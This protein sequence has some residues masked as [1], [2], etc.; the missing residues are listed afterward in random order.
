MNPNKETEWT[1]D[2]QEK[3]KR[4]AFQLNGLTVTEIAELMFCEERQVYKYL[5]G[6]SNIP[7]EKILRWCEITGE[8]PEDVNPRVYPSCCNNVINGYLGRY[9]EDA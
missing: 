8:K 6:T 7:P 9:K 5:D 2:W 1:P 3:K 4:R